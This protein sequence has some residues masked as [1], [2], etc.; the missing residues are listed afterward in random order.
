MIFTNNKQLIPGLNN[1]LLFFRLQSYIHSESLKKCSPGI[2]FTPAAWANLLD[3]N[4]S[5]MPLIASTEGPM[6]EIPAAS[7]KVSHFNCV[8]H[9]CFQFTRNK[10]HVTGRGR[11]EH[12]QQAFGKIPFLVVKINVD[13]KEILFCHWEYSKHIDDYIMFQKIKI[14]SKLIII[15]KNINSEEHHGNT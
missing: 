7:W 12:Q 2:V 9:S 4:L 13:K 8:Y 5:P 11:K 14:C 3:S 6:K 1:Y 15:E 10:L